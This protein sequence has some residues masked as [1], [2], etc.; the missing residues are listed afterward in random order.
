MNG[1]A[2]QF[3][4]AIKHLRTWV[5]LDAKRAS[6]ACA[7][8]GTSSLA[9]GSGLSVIGESQGGITTPDRCRVI[10]WHD[11]KYTSTSNLHYHVPCDAEF[12]LLQVHDVWLD[13]VAGRIWHA[14]DGR[15]IGVGFATASTTCA[16]TNLLAVN[17]QVSGVTLGYGA[18]TVVGIQF[19]TTEPS[20]SVIADAWQASPETALPGCVRHWCGSD[21]GTAGAAAPASWVDR[22]SGSVALTIT[23]AP[24]LVAKAAPK[25]PVGVVQIFG[26]SIAAGRRNVASPYDSDG[27][28]REWMLA[29]NLTAGR[30]TA[31]VGQNA[32]AD[33]LSLGV[34]SPKTFDRRH[35][36]VAGQSLGVGVGPALST[37]ASALST[38]AAS[39][40]LTILAFGINDLSYRI[41]TS[42]ES[43]ATAVAGFLADLDAALALVRAARPTA[44]ILV[45]NVLRAGTGGSGI[46]ATVQ[47]AIDSLNSQLPAVIVAA[48][49]TYGGVSLIDACAAVTPTQA[50]A[51]DPL[52][53]Y[54]KIHETDASKV[55]HSVPA[56][57]A[58]LAAA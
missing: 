19:S 39:D 52:V 57:A 6:S 5:S 38:Y 58:L 35:Q 27:G 42:G 18:M 25:R 45:Q 13:T 4:V 29:A 24:S 51:D 56:S 34:G 28:W 30:F 16:T 32:S 2:G 54:D 3:N 1:G 46:T 47:T 8:V 10:G 41:V 20:A 40:A 43:A 11:T 48:N 26:D 23:G 37:M 53:L 55:L 12:G 33:L 50:A 31:C 14:I 9:G 7:V 49:G 17:R 21:M 15:I 44:P 22:I 36:A